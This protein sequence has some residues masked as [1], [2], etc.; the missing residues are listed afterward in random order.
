MSK[1]KNLLA[2]LVLLFN[3]GLVPAATANNDVMRQIE[4]IASDDQ[5]MSGAHKIW[6]W[7]S[8]SLVI[9]IIISSISLS[10][11]GNWRAGLAVG[12]IGFTIIFVGSKLLSGLIG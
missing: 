10:M 4:S 7:I 9:I 1:I 3:C 8:I 11:T 6:K 5:M 2:V 12:G